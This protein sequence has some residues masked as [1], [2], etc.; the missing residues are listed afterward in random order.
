MKGLPQKGLVAV[1]GTTGTNTSKW[2]PALLRCGFT[3]RSL[4]RTPFFMQNILA[5]RSA[6]K[7]GIFA[8]PWGAFAMSVIDVSDVADVAASVAEGS[9]DDTAIDLTGPEALTAEAMAATLTRAAGCHV[10]FVSPDLADFRGELD[11][12]RTPAWMGDALVEIYGAMAEGRA[13]HLSRVSDGV[14]SVL[15]RPGHSFESFVL[16]SAVKSRAPSTR[17]NMNPAVAIERI[18]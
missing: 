6:A 11:Q 13:Q 1:I 8:Q 2:T 16:R 17:P 14:H 15:R 7:S 9:R 5:Q 4:V 12:L 18:I 3:V 10:A